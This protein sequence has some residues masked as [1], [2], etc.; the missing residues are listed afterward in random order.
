MGGFATVAAAAPASHASD[1]RTAEA[2]I[3]VDDAWGMAEGD[4]AYVGQLPLPGYRS[5]GSDGKTT[6]RDAII[7][8]TRRHAADPDYKARV[9]SWRQ[10]HPSHAEV[11]LFGDIAILTWVPDAVGR[12]GQVQSCD[13]FVYRGGHWR[14]VYSQHVGI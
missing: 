2:V 8:S 7:M 6:T 3:G 12:G 5:I 10:Q 9:A 11:A 13:I 1:A 14:A 4:V